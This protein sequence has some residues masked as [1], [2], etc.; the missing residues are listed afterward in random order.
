[1]GRKTCKAFVKK[2]AL[3]YVGIL[4]LQVG[5]NTKRLTQGLLSL[6]VCVLCTCTYIA[7]HTVGWRRKICKAFVKNIV[8]L[9]KG[10][11][12]LH[13]GTWRGC[14]GEYC[15][16]ISKT[17]VY[18]CSSSRSDNQYPYFVAHTASLKSWLKASY[19]KN[20]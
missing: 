17:S 11:L 14:G 5:M 6:I 18:Y 9:Y 2:I 3:F 20:I 13:S 4:K 7:L 16:T 19:I 10:I 15:I 1:M 8:L 12:K